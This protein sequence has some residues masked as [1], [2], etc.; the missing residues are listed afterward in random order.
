MQRL[1]DGR[2]G[3]LYGD[4][5]RC[6]PIEGGHAVLCIVARASRRSRT[7][8]LPAGSPAHDQRIGERL[9]RGRRDRGAA[10]DLHVDD[11]HGVPDYVF[12]LHPAQFDDVVGPLHRGHFFAIAHDNVRR[13]SGT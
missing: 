3:V 12:D 2:A 1:A 9:R 11:R 7:Q 5:D 4:E 13:Y 8:V 6:V 10:H